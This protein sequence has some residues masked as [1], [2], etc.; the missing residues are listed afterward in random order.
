M[1]EKS[2]IGTSASSENSGA[3][4]PTLRVLI[5]DDSP[6]VRGLLQRALESGFRL[7]EVFEASDG[8]TAIRELTK[9]RMDLIITDLEMPGVNGHRFLQILQGNPLLKRKKVLVFSS[10]ISAE[11][12][13][14][15]ADQPHI[16]FLGKPASPADITQA[17]R[18]LLGPIYS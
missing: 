4:T 1:I 7:C 14:E 17:A 6:T 13:A 5:I 10:A 8:R 11:L 18:T 9:G 12:K 2:A 16:G 3:G 15:L